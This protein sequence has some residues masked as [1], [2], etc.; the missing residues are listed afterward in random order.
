MIC[1]LILGNVESARS[2]TRAMQ[3]NGEIK[4]KVR[5]AQRL[6]SDRVMCYTGKKY[7]FRIRGPGFLKL[8]RLPVV[9]KHLLNATMY[10]ALC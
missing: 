10:Q 5:N 3:F 2:V 4:F 1:Y 8:T 7:G 6:F 9:N